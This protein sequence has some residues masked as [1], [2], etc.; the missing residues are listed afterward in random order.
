MNSSPVLIANALASLLGTLT[1]VDQVAVDN[2]LPPIETQFAAV[3]IPPFGQQ[4][5]VDVLTTAGSKFVPGSQ[6]TIESHRI[7]CELW[8]KIDTGKLAATIQRARAL[9]SEAISVLLANPTLNNTVEKVGNYS[10][11]ST[12]GTTGT[13][14]ETETFDR[15]VQVGGVPYIVI[16]IIVPVVAYGETR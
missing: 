12:R 2:Y 11:G 1:S 14:I 7:R 16:A 5:R 3:V 10:G 8:V 6:Q 4:T 13:A 9:P 15:P